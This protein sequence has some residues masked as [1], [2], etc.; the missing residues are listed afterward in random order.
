MICA[1]RCDL[2]HARGPEARA[3][4]CVAQCQQLAAASAAVASYGVAVRASLVASATGGRW[5]VTGYMTAGWARGLG[6]RGDHSGCINQSNANNPWSALR[7]AL[8]LRIAM[9][10]KRGPRLGQ[11]QI[12]NGATSRKD[13]AMDLVA[14]FR[15]RA[16]L[17]AAPLDHLRQN[18][19]KGS[20]TTLGGVPR[21][22]S[23][24]DAASSQSACSTGGVGPKCP[25]KRMY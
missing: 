13:A 22:V 25:T 23:F 24:I 6:L 14:C 20:R 15:G 8:S 2:L 16:K 3:R 7:R 10:A 11:R 21:D 19:C 5:D 9:Y 18:S 12:R 17:E 1:S 4:S